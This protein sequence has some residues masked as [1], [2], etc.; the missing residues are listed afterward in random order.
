MPE[1]IWRL[2]EG[3]EEKAAALAGE[4]G[5]AP[6]VARLLVN[7]GLD[8]GEA[9]RHFMRAEP[10]ALADPMLFADMK[11]AVARLASAIE[12]GEKI[13]VH[14]DYDADGITAT[15]FCLRFP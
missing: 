15:A 6:L 5:C 9:A 14:G 7:R 2:Q 8:R 1:A 3:G 4:L 11:K 12:G 10:E 13:V